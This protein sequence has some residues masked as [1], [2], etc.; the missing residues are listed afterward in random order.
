MSYIY[1]LSQIQYSEQH[2]VGNN[3]FILSQLLQDECSI[4]PGLIVSNDLSASLLADLDLNDTP[5]S[6]LSNL[7]I[8]SDNDFY[9]KLQSVA[10]DRHQ[11]IERT[12]LPQEWLS[13]ISSA[14]QQLNSDCL[15]LQ[16]SLAFPYQNLESKGRLWRSPTCNNN[17]QAIAKGIKKIWLELFTAGNLLRWH[18]LGLSIK[19]LSLAILIRPLP[20]AYASGII[21]VQ[22]NIVKIQANWGLEQSLLQGEVEP[23]EYYVDLSTGYILSRHLGHKNYAY[24]RQDLAT[25]E[26]SEECEEC[27][28]A[29]IPE[30]TH[31]ETYVLDGQ[32]IAKLL[33]LTQVVLEREP[34]VKY[35]VWTAPKIKDRTLINFYFTQ[36]AFNLP[37]ANKRATDNSQILAISP[38]LNGVAAAPGK[39]VAKMAIVNDFDDHDSKIPPHTIIVTKTVLPHHFQLLKQAAGIITETGGATSHGA[40]LARELQ[41]PAIANAIN[42]TKIFQNNLEV[43]LDGDEGKVY[44]AAA[45]YLAS[46][47]LS[48]NKFDFKEPIATQLMVNL[49]QPESISKTSNLPIDG[50]GLLRSELMLAELLT[51]QFLSQRSE[52]VFRLRFL[53]TLTDFLRQF[54]DAF[55]PRPIFYRSTDLYAQDTLSSILGDRGT[56]NYLSD[57]SLFSLELEALARVINE[58]Y[59]NFKLILPFVRSVEEFKFCYRAIENAG[60]IGNKSFQVWMMAEVPSVIFLL[61]EYIRAGVRGIAIGTNDLTQLLLG[62]DREQAK[63]SNRG[64]NANHPAMHQAIARLI[65]IAKANNIGCC[66]CGQAPVDY[67]ELIDQ[68]INWGINAISV[69]PEAIATT[70]Q[71][72]ARAEKRILLRNKLDN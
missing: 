68:L 65:A 47:D 58:G 38:L 31:S 35:L 4:L 50:I 18:K 25:V 64:L 36:L 33:Q 37:F 20:A 27:L 17:P 63:F 60:L 32:A 8:H 39:V 40:I 6:R 30:A 66:I 12:T 52:T 24:Q 62:V 5:A 19:D 9:Q 49:S 69:E 43:F 7:P 54:G 57:S 67:P 41:I 22:E 72:I 3:F 70:Y 53:N 42:A 21:E 46:Q 26:V 59:S 10:G 16:P 61:P 14:A 55:A 71:A 23:D 15:I 29:Y 45:Y 56:Y 51:P 11:A 2:L 44:P 1:W 34:E 48:S 28:V 13:K